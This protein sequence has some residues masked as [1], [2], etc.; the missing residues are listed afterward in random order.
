MQ[1][2]AFFQLY[3]TGFKSIIENSLLYSLSAKIKTETEI[4]SQNLVAE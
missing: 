3:S 1:S 2:R 4:C